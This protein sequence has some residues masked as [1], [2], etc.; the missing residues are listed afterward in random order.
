MRLWGHQSASCAL[1]RLPNSHFSMYNLQHIPK[2]R[3]HVDMK[4]IET[5][6]KCHLGFDVN[7]LVKIAHKFVGMK[8]AL[9]YAIFVLFHVNMKWPEN[10]VKQGVL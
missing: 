3:I 6:L 1:F 7:K 5:P 2:V 10:N 9:F 8:H 4:Y